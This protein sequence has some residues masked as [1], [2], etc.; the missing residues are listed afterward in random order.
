MFLVISCKVHEQML[1]LISDE[2]EWKRQYS[3]WRRKHILTSTFDNLFVVCSSHCPWYYLE[4]SSNVLPFSV[5]LMRWNSFCFIL[6][7]CCECYKLSVVILNWW[8]QSFFGRLYHLNL[9]LI[10]FSPTVFSP[11]IFH[12][13]LSLQFAGKIDENPFFILHVFSTFLIPLIIHFFKSKNSYNQTIFTWQNICYLNFFCEW[14]ILDVWKFLNLLVLF[15]YIVAI[16]SI[17]FPFLNKCFQ[18]HD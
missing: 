8:F 2:F 10:L 1:W 16:H 18:K 9:K 11:K 13:V 14:C 15:S 5:I 3:W 12:Y 4:S 7:L 6:L 17:L